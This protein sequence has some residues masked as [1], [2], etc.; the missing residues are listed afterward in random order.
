GETNVAQD[1]GF[2]TA[3]PAGQIGDKIFTDINGNGLFDASESG[4]AGINVQLCGDLDDDNGTPQ[5]CRIEITDANGDYL[6]GDGLQGD[7]IT[8]DGAD[9]GLPGTNGTEDYTLTVLNPPAAATNTADPDGLA[10]SVAQLTLP[11]GISNVD[12]DFG[13]V[14]LS[15]LAGSVWLDEDLDGVLDIEETGIAGVQVQLIRDG[16]VV[17]T[18]VTDANGDY[19]FTAINPGEYTVNIID[20]TAPSGLQNAAGP[21]GIDPRPV[22][23]VQGVEVKDINF[24]YVPN[25]NTGAI[26]DRV[27]FDANQDGIQ[28]SGEAGIEGVTLNLLDSAGVTVTATTN[29][30][31]HYLFTDVSFGTDYIVSISPMD[32]NLTGKTPT[33]GPQSEASYIGNPVDLNAS[34]SVITDIDFGFYSGGSNTLVD[35]FWVDSDRDGLRGVNEESIAYVTVNLYND[36]NNDGIGD[37]ANAD[38]Q[39]D[40]V[41]TNTSDANGEISFTGLPNS[42]FVIAVTDVNTVLNNYVG[43]TLEALARLSDTIAITGG[44]TD[45]QLSFG[46]NQAGLIAGTIYAD[47][48]SSSTQDSG[49][50]GISAVTVTLTRETSPGSNVFTV[51]E[52]FLTSADGSYDFNVNEAANYRVVVSA[53]VGNQTEDPDVTVDDQTDITLILGESSVGNDFGYEDAAGTFTMGGTVFIDPNKNGIEDADDLGIEGVTLNLI[54][55]NDINGYDVVDGMLDVNGDSRISAA[56]D[57]VVAG[58]TIIDGMFDID[59]NGTINEADSGVVGPFNILEGVVNL[60]QAGVATQSSNFD[61]VRLASVAVDGNP[62]GSPVG[63]ALATTGK[64]S[65]FEFW[66]VDLG[67]VQL[68]SEVTIFNRDDGFQGRLS[69]VFVLVADTAFPSDTHQTND[70]SAARAVADFEFQITEASLGVTADPV[71]SIGGV[72]G[73]FV[74]IQKSGTNTNGTDSDPNQLDIAEV[75][76]T[77]SFILANSDAVVATTTTDA[78]G[79]YTFSGLSAGDYSVAVTDNAVRLA[80]YDITSGLDALDR[81]IDGGNETDVDFGYIREE[82]TA[83]IAGEVF[84]D[85]NQNG[86]AEDG[87]LDLSNVRVHLC[88]SPTVGATC[89]PADGSFV[90]TTTTDFNGEYIFKGLTP[91]QYVVDSDSA[92]IP[93]GLDKTVDPALISISEGEKVTDV[94]HGYQPT[95]II[96]TNNNAGVLSGFVWIDVLPNGDFDANEAPISGVTIMVFD[97]TDPAGSSPVLTTTTGPDGRWIISNIVTELVDS[98]FVAYQ[99]NDSMSSQGIDAAAGADLNEVQPTNFPI[100]DNVYNPVPLMSDEDNNIGDLNFGFDPAGADLGSISGIIYTDADQDGDHGAVSPTVD[101]EL[102][103]VTVN[104]LDV[105]G[106]VLATTATDSTGEYTFVG[107]A[108]GDATTGINYQVVITDNINVTADLVPLE[109]LPPLINLRNSAMLRNVIGQD[110]GFISSTAFFSIGNRFFFDTNGDGIADDVEPGIEGVTVQCW[111][112][113]DQSETPNDASIAS[114]LVVPEAGIDNLLRTVVTD[115]NGEY[116]CT[117]LPSGNYIVTVVEA[118][119]FDEAADGTLVTGNAADNFAKNWSYALTLSSTQ[120]NFAADFGVSGDNM[121]GGTIFVE[122]EGLVE[123]AGT[124]ITP[125]DLDGVLGGNPD[126]SVVGAP[127]A[128]IDAIA[129]IPVDLL[130]EEDDGTFSVIQSTITGADGGYNFAGLPDG[131]YQVVVRPTG[132]GIDGYGQTG[133]PDLVFIETNQSDLVCDSDTAALCDNTALT[134]ISLSAGANVTGINFGYQRGFATTPVTM[135]FFSATRSGGAV[136][137]VWETT[138]EVGHAGFQVFA[139]TSQGWEL[140]NEELLVGNITVN[141]DFEAKQYAFEA[142][143]DAKW[144]ALVDVSDTEE[145][146][147]RGPFEVGQ[148]YGANFGE[149]EMFDWSLVQANTVQSFAEIKDLVDSRLNQRVIEVEEHDPEFEAYLNDIDEQDG[150]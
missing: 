135:N 5:T 141:S 3:L 77:P 22:L 8:A 31:G 48:N 63:T 2:Q 24:G 38:G 119:G 142:Q 23:I 60:A 19:S 32:P 117:S 103:G 27:W 62:S 75:K 136:S 113:V 59:L 71:V 34:G 96:G 89:L 45:S 57:G 29:T 124:T 47:P 94:A 143:S 128:D 82:A 79:N 105:V 99:M 12:Q 13:Y 83:S 50:A 18:A 10:P 101:T 49:E 67:S 69:N 14:E 7:G 88:T 93:V 98:L 118:N 41:A 145:V 76:I 90:A 111:A 80:G 146:I 16:L 107:L 74:R 35:A 46:Y 85:E 150:E 87:E 11:S 123:P 43:T 148:E 26:G 65:Q 25:N 114:N 137:F 116:V 102:Q 56:D 44:V 108:V 6:F 81:T 68:L 140:L 130:F 53:P 147:A 109:T 106:N 73:R 1:F 104:L 100:G 95:P 84:I 39:P 64:T 36:A 70:L 4:I 86:M 112:D 78:L 122:A 129:N 138:N 97:G 144:F 110:A 120:P 51:N 30:N 132:T 17:A 58:V 131:N 91:A 126:T 115:E 52:T 72:A 9:L 55:R 21:N 37:D 139:R 54:D 92:D 149:K 66:E 15:S 28:D 40:L 133:D 61:A 33:V 134:P 20:D 42:S 127:A 125:G 121:L